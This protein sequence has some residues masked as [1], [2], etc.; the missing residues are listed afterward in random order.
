MKKKICLFD[1]E[2]RENSRRRTSKIQRTIVNLVNGEFGSASQSQIE[3]N[4]KEKVKNDRR[5]KFVVGRR[6]AEETRKKVKRESLIICTKIREVKTQEN[7]IDFVRLEIKRK[8]KRKC[9]CF[10]STFTESVERL[11]EATN[12]SPSKFLYFSLCE[13]DN[14]RAH[15]FR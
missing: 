8:R 6:K 10:C 14:F 7:E 2:I 9:F 11:V 1:S 13:F 3:F 5:T 4:E 12:F 15:R